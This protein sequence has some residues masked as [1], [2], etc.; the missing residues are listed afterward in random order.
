MKDINSYLKLFLSFQHCNMLSTALRPHCFDELAV[1]LIMDYT[2]PAH[3]VTFLL[4]SRLSLISLFLN[5]LGVHLCVYS[6]IT[7]PLRWMHA[8]FSFSCV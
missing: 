4:L 2:Y 8:K 6:E 3:E 7:E 5:N 1:N